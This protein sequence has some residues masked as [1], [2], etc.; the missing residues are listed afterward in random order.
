MWVNPVN[1]WNGNECYFRLFL[2]VWE[3]AKRNSWNYFKSVLKTVLKTVVNTNYSP[4]IR[5]KYCK[6]CPTHPQHDTMPII[7]ISACLL[8][9]AN[10]AQAK[11]LHN[12][13]HFNKTSRNIYLS[14]DF[15]LAWQPPS[16]P[17][18]P[19][20]RGFYITNNDA[21]QSVGLLRTSDQLFAET[22][23]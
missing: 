3:G 8:I 2:N 4:Q 17:G 21:L 7:S 12:L 9:S 16:G 13:L 20:S 5:H 15:F 19:H 10:T 23:T 18:L 14:I 6:I 11:M 1:M 22:P